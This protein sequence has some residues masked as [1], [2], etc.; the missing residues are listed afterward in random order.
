MTFSEDEDLHGFV[1][2][3]YAGDILT[4]RSTT[5]YAFIFRGGAISWM[6]KLQLTATISTCEAEYVATATAIKEGLWIQ[7][8]FR[9][10]GI[11]ISTIQIYGD[12]QGAL[13]RLAR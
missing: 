3:D 12:N 7:T 8:L 5:G 1:D 11:N 9:D 4:R 13:K 10:I 6:S 2:V